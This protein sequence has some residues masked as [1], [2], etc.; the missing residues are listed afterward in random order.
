VRYP[1]REL[2]KGFSGA[3]RGIVRIRQYSPEGLPC[4]PVAQLHLFHGCHVTF[5][6]FHVW[7][8]MFSSSYRNVVATASARGPERTLSLVAWRS[9][10]ASSR[11][12][13]R[14]LCRSACR[15]GCSLPVGEPE[16]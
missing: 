4:K 16:F 12:L 6:I 13:N 2:I 15:L 1:G 5:S 7:H 3:L 11:T 14:V 10:D 8:F 9:G